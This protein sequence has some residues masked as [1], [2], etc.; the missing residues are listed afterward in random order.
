MGKRWATCYLRLIARPRDRRNFNNRKRN[1]QDRKKS[2]QENMSVVKESLLD[3]VA[4]TKRIIIGELVTKDP[5]IERMSNE[6]ILKQDENEVSRSMELTVSLQKQKNRTRKSR[7]KGAK[8]REFEEYVTKYDVVA[9]LAKAPSGLSIGQ[10][11]RR[12][13]LKA[14]KDLR[15]LLAGIKIN[16]IVRVTAAKA[17]SQNRILKLCAVQIYELK[18]L[19]LLDTEATPNLIS[20]GLLKKI[21]VLAKPTKIGSTMES[22]DYMSCKDVVKH[23]PVRFD[24]ATTIMASSAVEGVPVDLLIGFSELKRLQTNLDIGGQFAEF[25]IRGEEFRVALQPETSTFD[26][27]QNRA[28]EDFKTDSCSNDDEVSST[29]SSDKEEMVEMVG[30][31]EKEFETDCKS[32]AD[33]VLDSAKMKVVEIK[34]SHLDKSIA[35]EIY[36]SLDGSRILT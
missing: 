2:S 20:A 33:Q 16:S 6:R 4:V 19:A 1:S 13:G 11:C 10:L 23:V 30:L 34:L 5:K 28:D 3:A 8:N 12:D 22:R 17:S 25:K 21:G 27:N 26:E 7:K 36:S 35:E 9:E 24:N 18:C 31:L 15:H 29:E 14:Q 32:Q